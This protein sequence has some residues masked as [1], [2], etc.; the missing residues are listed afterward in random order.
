MPLARI[1][2]NKEN[3]FCRPAAAVRAKAASAK[4]KAKAGLAAGLGLGLPSRRLK[5]KRST[6]VQR[7][8]AANGKPKAAPAV[9]S[10]PAR[11]SAGY[12]K[13]PLSLARPAL[14]QIAELELEGDLVVSTPKHSATSFI[15]SS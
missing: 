13:L 4:V 9:A 14:P 15:R 3:S 7:A 10:Q 6:S 2:S 1:S 8:K 5:G 12:I 11:S